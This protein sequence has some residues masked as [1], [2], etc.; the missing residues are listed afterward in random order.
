MYIKTQMHNQTH[1]T[2]Y[3]HTYTQSHTQDTLFPKWYVFDK[4]MRSITQTHTHTKQRQLDVYKQPK[5]HPNIHKNTHTQDTIQFNT[6]IWIYF[7][8][9]VAKT[10]IILSHTHIQTHT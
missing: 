7:D 2:M 3:T 9:L 1:T 4:R 10:D 6:L 5:K 8:V